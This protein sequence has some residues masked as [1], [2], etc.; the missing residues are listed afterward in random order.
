MIKLTRV[1]STA[2][3]AP[4]VFVIAGGPGLSSLTLR[5]L[6]LL[7]RSFELIYLDMQGTNGS[8]YAGKKSFP[9]LAE[10]VAEVVRSESGQKFILGHSYG[11][12]LAA[13][14]FKSSNASGLVCI[15][16]PFSKASLDAA[17]VSYNENKTAT[18]EGS[19]IYWEKMQDDNSFKIWLSDYGDIWFKNPKGKNLILQDLVSSQFFKDNRSDIS[20]HSYVLGDVAA[21]DTTK[22]FIA[23]TEDKLLPTKVL[24]N[25]S[26]SGKFEFFEIE[27]ASHFVTLDQPEKVAKLIEEKLL[28]S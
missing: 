14:A 6:D 13:A 19:R 23:G 8:E 27:N 22:I 16:T 21:I 9:E 3:N 24:K 2:L 11:G 15:A 18:L 25:D 5:N 4:K 28:R 17:S 1:N 20:N 26:Q 7:K 10:A 12:L